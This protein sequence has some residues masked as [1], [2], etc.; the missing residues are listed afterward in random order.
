MDAEKAERFAQ[1]ILKL[2]QSK[3]ILREDVK[4][5]ENP[6]RDIWYDL[7]RDIEVYLSI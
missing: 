5:K 3:C 2:I 7:F 4:D 1:D 6:E